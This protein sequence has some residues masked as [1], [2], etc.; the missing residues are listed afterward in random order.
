MAVKKEATISRWIGLSTD[1]K[2]TSVPVGSTFFEYDTKL[3]C[4]TYDGTNWVIKSIPYGLIFAGTCNTGMTAS[5]TTI[6]CADLAGYGNDYFNGVGGLFYMQVV[7]NA[8]DPTAAP[9]GEIRK[10]TDYVSSSGTFTVDAFSANV[11]E[12]DEI[13][14]IHHTLVAILTSDTELDYFI[15]AD[16][17]DFDV[18]DA[19][20]DT[21]RW[22]PGYITG[23][24][25]GSA[26]IDTTTSDKLMVKV[27]PDATPTE[28]RYGVAHALP[29]YADFFTVTVDLNCTW[30]AT[31]SATAKGLGL[32]ISKGTAYDSQNYL[33]LERQKGTS[34]NRF[35]ASGKLNNVSVTAANANTTDDVVALKIERWDNVWRLYYSTVQGPSYDWVLLAQYE[36]SSVY[37]TNQVVLFLEAYSVGSADTESAQGDFGTFRYY[38]GA[39]GGGQFIAGDYSSGWVTPDI[40]GNVFERQEALQKA[41]NV[42]DAA[43]LTGFEEDGSGANLF[44]TLIAVQSVTTGAGTITTI[45]DTARTEGADYWNAHEVI[46]LGGAAVGQISSIVDDD[47]AGTLTVRPAFT[48]APGASVAYAIT[49]KLATPVPTADTGDNYQP[50]DV[51]GNKTD[52][53]DY[54]PGATAS[55][56]MA[57]LKGALGVQVIGEGTFTTSSATVPADTSRTELNDYWNGSWLMAVTGAN[58]MQPRLIVDFVSTGGVFN[59]DGNQPFNTAPGLV[60]Y[61][62]L[63][64]NSQLVSGV[65]QGLNSTPAHVIGNKSDTIPA[66]NLA[67][68]ASDSLVRHVK[69][70]MERVGATAADPDDSLLTI[71]GQR[72][73]AA[74]A[75]SAVPANTDTLVMHL[76]AIRETVGQTPAD[77]DDS[78]LTVAGQRDDAIPAMSAAPSDTSTLV[79]QIKAC[80]ERIGATP[81]DPDDSVLTNLGQRDDAATNDDMS[82]IATTSIEAKLRLIL[83]RLSTD[84]FTATIQGSA[85]TALDTMLAQLATYLSASG[86]AWNVQVNNQTARTNLEQTIEDVLAVLGCD[87]AN[88]FNPSIGGTARTDMD[89]AF[90][91][92]GTALGAEYDGSPDLYDTLVTGYD[93]GG[94]S[95]NA[96]G[97]VLERL[98]IV[99]EDIGDPSAASDTLYAQV[100]HINKLGVDVTTPPIANTLADTLHKDTNYTYDNT[101]DSLEALSD[102]V[103]TGIL[104]IEADAGTTA[105]DIIDAAALT[106]GTDD[107]WKGAMLVSINGQ[108]AG[109]ARPVISFAQ[110]TD[111]LTVYPAFLNTPDVGDDF[112]LISNW[113]TNAW[114]E[115]TDVPVNISAI[116]ASET[117]VFDLSVAATSYKVNS[118]RLKSADPGAQVMTVKLYELINDVSTVVGTYT[119]T[120]S[121]YTTYYSLVD[122]FGVNQLAGDNLKITVQM[123]GGAAVAVTGQYHYAL[124]KTG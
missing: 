52:A 71:N 26:D 67:P 17:D 20:A 37:L 106:Q 18:P 11:E 73:D 24:E 36:D 113:R 117:S 85:R 46:L 75:M 120:T 108:N 34:I 80:L 83:N 30:G 97:S 60:A 66:M 101:T 28:A 96:D 53:V 103:S 16:M 102:K 5:A 81:A 107:W 76:K 121:S 105:T 98:E 19:D 87:G 88:V 82:D 123:D 10:V 40:D 47:G 70:I 61:V 33:L 77:P 109:Q 23:T 100:R 99:Q 55:S 21:D 14:I 42:T 84:A 39:G 25:G 119:I 43:T 31:N 57:L 91:A 79:Q 56:L 90:A 58:A 29:L 9:G 86:A 1:T 35:T 89:A 38:V 116:A 93:S 27:D 3:L 65:D 69:A 59:L 54:T 62:I 115:Q 110:A 48:A 7:K 104:S 94:T 2:P 45:A 15:L 4:I 64:P 78:L 13:W 22:T 95:P 8:D 32:I 49:K 12:T 44:N 50:R 124:A 118:L 112:I 72:D 111:T 92:L 63:S 74:P 51:T 6:A 41:V 122:M 114:D 68:S